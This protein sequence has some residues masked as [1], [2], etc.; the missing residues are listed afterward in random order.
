MTWRELHFYERESGSQQTKEAYTGH[1]QAFFANVLEYFN[2]R[3]SDR[4][5]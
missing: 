1:G 5:E 2:K 3:P 4:A